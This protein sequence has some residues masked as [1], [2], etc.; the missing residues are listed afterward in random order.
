MREIKFRVWHG[1]EDGEMVY[2]DESDFLIA[3][4]GLVLRASNRRNC[5]PLNEIKWVGTYDICG[6]NIST[7]GLILMQYTGLKDKNGTEI[8]EGDIVR[9]VHNKNDSYT[10]DVFFERGSWKF[11]KLKWGLWE[12]AASIEIIG[13]KYE[14]PELLEAK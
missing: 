7:N 10:G 14:H 6:A 5:A 4:N 12:F 8:Y 9:Y 13:N 2:Y 11:G 1:Y 3:L